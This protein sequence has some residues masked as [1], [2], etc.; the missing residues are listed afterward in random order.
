MVVVRKTRY[1]FRNQ[2]KNIITIM[3]I[4]MDI[5]TTMIIAMITPILI[6]TNIIFIPM[7]YSWKWI[8]FRRTS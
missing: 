1:V 3:I 4:I 6:L 8:Y 5:I 2:E 7:K